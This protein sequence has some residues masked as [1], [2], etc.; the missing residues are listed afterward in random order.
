MTK[1]LNISTDN[2]LGGSSA[3]DV[4]VASQKAIKEYVDA[5][6]GAVDIDNSTITTNSSDELQ[7]VATVNQN[8]ATGA[9]NPVY[10]WVG[11]LAE[12]ND[13]QVA[14]NHPEW[15]C[16]ITDDY[17][18]TESMVTNREIG[19]LVYS[20]IPLVNAGLHLADGVLIDGTGVYKEFY[21]H[22][23]S[24]YD[25]GHTSIFATEAD[26]QTAV[27]TYGK[28]G[29]Y[30]LDTTNHTIRLPKIPGFVEGTLTEADI[31]ALV[32]AGLP[33]ITGSIVSTGGNLRSG[34]ETV[35]GALYVST[36]DNAATGGSNRGYKGIYFDASRSNSVYGNSTTVQPESIKV[37]V[38]VVI[39][40]KTKT[41]IA[42]DIDEIATDLN[43]KVSLD[44]SWGTPSATYDDLTLG[45]SGA[46]YTAPA[47]GYFFFIKTANGA[48]QSV[49]LSNTKNSMSS[50]M[51]SVGNSN[52]CR[53]WL[54]VSKG[55]SIAATYNT[56]GATQY[57]RFIYAQKTN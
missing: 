26:W 40:N 25:A 57:F 49:K 9:Q 56:G 41:A 48:N 16:F 43:G 54:P 1:F 32:A 34:T 51:I 17:S 30:V 6:S 42:A 35:S 2:T 11:T 28:C 21:E 46:E 33:N 12:Y 47:D 19:E 23:S 55:D 7:A 18:D 52:W 36:A 38:Y 10:D 37:Y 22:M 50:E 14:L 53:A 5:N 13:Q 39:A 15:I 44:S 4:L 3:S 24:V 45:A 27:S 20:T 31:G 29:K 8:T